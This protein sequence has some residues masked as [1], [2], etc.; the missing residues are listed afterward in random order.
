MSIRKRLFDLSIA[1]PL[2]VL[3]LPLC[4][5]IALCITLESRGSRLTRHLR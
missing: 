4:A 1:I 2:L 3:S 5:L